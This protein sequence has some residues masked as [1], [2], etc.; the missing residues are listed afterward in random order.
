MTPIYESRNLMGHYR[1]VKVTDG[2]VNY[3]K[4][5]YGLVFWF[6]RKIA[7]VTYDILTG[8]SIGCHNRSVDKNPY[9]NHE[10]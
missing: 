6:C 2:L 1:D 4:N 7:A 9:S 3:N 8:I 10:N 5:K